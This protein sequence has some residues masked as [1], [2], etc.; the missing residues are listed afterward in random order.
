M[1]EIGGVVF[2]SEWLVPAFESG[3]ADFAVKDLVHG[4]IQDMMEEHEYNGDIQE[5]MEEHEGNGECGICLY[6]AWKLSCRLTSVI[7]MF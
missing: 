4:D 1:H 7:H 5:M 3:E 6:T 2:I